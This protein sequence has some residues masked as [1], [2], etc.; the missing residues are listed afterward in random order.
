MSKMSIDPSL[1]QIKTFYIMLHLSL[2]GTL[3]NFLVYFLI[4]AYTHTLK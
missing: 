2:L 4:K 3:K 1:Q